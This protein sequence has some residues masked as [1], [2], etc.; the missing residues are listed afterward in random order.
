MKPRTTWTLKEALPFL[1]SL[2]EAL[3]PTWHVALGGSVLM[4]GESL[5]DIDVLVYPT[6]TAS[7]SPSERKAALELF[8]LKQLYSREVVFRKW[9]REGSTDSKHVEVWQW[10]GKRV[11]LFFVA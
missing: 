4:K 11:D 1:R 7:N 3:Y 6:S 8:G 10:Q 5:K 9:L 2:G